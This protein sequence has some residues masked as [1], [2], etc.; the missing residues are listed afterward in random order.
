L[1]PKSAMGP[2]KGV[3]APTP[4]GMEGGGLPNKRAWERKVTL[5]RLT[6][7]RTSRESEQAATA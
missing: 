4:L 7:R 1:R 6:G 5:H 3:D 2:S